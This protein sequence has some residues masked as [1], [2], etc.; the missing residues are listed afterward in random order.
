MSRLNLPYGQSKDPLPSVLAHLSMS[1]YLPID[2]K[3]K[4]ILI[5]HLQPYAA[6]FYV[7]LRTCAK[8]RADIKL[9]GG[10]G[11]PWSDP[12][13]V[14]R[15][16]VCRHGEPLQYQIHILPVCSGSGR[17]PSYTLL[18]TIFG[19]GWGVVLTEMVRIGNTTEDNGE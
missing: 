8:L 6:N 12:R 4:K 1:I 9:A 15:S 19:Q 3:Q 7:P 13:S 16:Q 2:T 14:N 11:G 5:Q 17:P 18:A 10:G